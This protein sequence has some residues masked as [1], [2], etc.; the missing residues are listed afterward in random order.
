MPNALAATVEVCTHAK[1]ERCW[2]SSPTSAPTPPTR[3]CAAG[4]LRRLG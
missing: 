1:C 2:R 3:R 4:V